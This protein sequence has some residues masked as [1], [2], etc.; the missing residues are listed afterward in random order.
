MFISFEGMDGS[1]K[2]TQI[3]LTADYLTTNG[4]DVLTVREPGGTDIGQY[5]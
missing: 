3:Q 5:P 1:G 4:Y 2:T